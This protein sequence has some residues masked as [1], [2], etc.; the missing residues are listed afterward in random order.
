MNDARVIFI[1]FA[2]REENMEIARPYF[3]RLLSDYPRAELH[4][5]NLTRNE[6]DNQYVRSRHDPG[7]RVYVWNDLWPG[8]NDWPKGVCRKKLRRPR[9]CGCDECRAAPYE[10]V[11]AWYAKHPEYADAV[12]CKTDDDVLFFET[13]RF[14]DVLEALAEHPNAVF[15]A[16]VINNVVSAK[17]YPTLRREV[18]SAWGPRTQRE[19]FDLHALPEFARLCHDWFLS[20]WR[21]W[22]QDTL[23]VV[24]TVPG[25]RISINFIAFTYPTLLRM[26]KAMQHNAFHRI[27]DEG[28]VD[29]NFLPRIVRSFTVAHL[30]FGP[31]RVGL[32]DDVWD[33]YRRRYAELA[34]E[35][36]ND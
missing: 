12:L 26:A 34:K 28:T 23:S 31:Q 29:Q 1:V 30:Q 16:N 18:L 20:G 13:K 19:W 4:L 22:T 27:G 17:H 33:E 2:G 21:Y 35:Y 3:D 11:Y 6:S 8:D 15:S 36:L 14:G 5:W 25:E 7:A 24:R 32:S 9:S 10:R